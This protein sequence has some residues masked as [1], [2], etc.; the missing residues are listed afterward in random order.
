MGI[1]IAADKSFFCPFCIESVNLIAAK[2]W[3]KKIYTYGLI[4]KNNNNACT[5]GLNLSC[6]HV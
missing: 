6:M 2:I 1:K 5:Q 4:I 3:Y